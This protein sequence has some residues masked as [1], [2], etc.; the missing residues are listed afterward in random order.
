[1]YELSF[2]KSQRLEKVFLQTK[3]T[4]NDLFQIEI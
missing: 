3:Q 1:M 4:K 2:S